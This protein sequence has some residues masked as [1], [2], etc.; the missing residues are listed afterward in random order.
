VIVLR[1][2]EDLDD[3]KIAEILDCS[4]GTVRTHAKR[5]LDTLRN[6]QGRSSEPMGAF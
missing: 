3:A 6:R 1:Y 5:A 2:Y 4:A